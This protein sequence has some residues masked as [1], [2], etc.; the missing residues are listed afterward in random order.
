MLEITSYS[1]SQAGV[2]ET[3]DILW[4]DVEWE[5]CWSSDKVD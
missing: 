3:M 2:I 1:Y 5:R 4:D